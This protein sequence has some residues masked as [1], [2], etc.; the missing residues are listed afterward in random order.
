[1]GKHQGRHHGKHQSK[2]LYKGNTTKYGAFFQNAITIP[3]VMDNADAIT[4]LLTITA[5]S[6]AL[7]V[8]R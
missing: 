4:N 7:M 3:E 8:R 5:L 2:P 6:A 1:M